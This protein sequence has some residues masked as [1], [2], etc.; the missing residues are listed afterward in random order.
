[1]PNA[2]TTPRSYRVLITPR[3]SA[4]TEDLAGD[5]ALHHPNFSKDDILTIL[6]AEDE[7]VLT[8]LLNGEQVTKTGSFT[9]FFSC[10]GRLDSPGRPAAA[11][12]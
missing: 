3:N 4:D 7:A 9:W 10:T 1:V 8:R 2:L 5:I 12:G 11:P 6:N